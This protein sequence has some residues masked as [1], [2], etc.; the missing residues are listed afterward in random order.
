MKLRDIPTVGQLTALWK[1]GPPEDFCG[2]MAKIAQFEFGTGYPVLGP[3]GCGCGSED[4]WLLDNHAYDSQ[5]ASLG[6]AVEGSWL[7]AWSRGLADNVDV[8]VVACVNCDELYRLGNL[9]DAVK[10]VFQP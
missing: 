2:A 6:V 3:N 5:T 1:Q 9:D 4:Y 10:V 7:E 8:N